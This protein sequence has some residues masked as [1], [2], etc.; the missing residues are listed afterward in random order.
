MLFELLSELQVVE[1]REAEGPTPVLACNFREY[2]A[3]R[4]EQRPSLRP[5]LTYV[6]RPEH[7]RG[8]RPD[9]VISLPG[10]GANDVEFRDG[11]RIVFNRASWIYLR[12]AAA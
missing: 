5:H 2:Q 7:A 6:A 12:E 3:F 8:L 10:A 9:F 11:L 1:I 4:D